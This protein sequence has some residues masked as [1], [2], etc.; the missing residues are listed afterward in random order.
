MEDILRQRV[1]FL[2]KA[3]KN[4]QL[5]NIEIELCKRDI[6]HFFR[7]HLYTDTNTNLYHDQPSVIPFIPYQFQEELVTEI[8]SSIVN[9]TL[10]ISERTDL[11]NVFIEKS[12][13]MWVSWI[14][15]AIL[16][17]WFIFH[18]H[19]YHVISQK[20]TDVD[21]IWDIRSLLEKARFILN[22]LPNWM[23]PPW[24]TK[25]TGTEYNKYMSLSRS[26]NTGGITGESANPNASRSGTYNAIFMD[27]M[28]FMANA[29]TIN[30]AAAAA[31]PCRIFN[32]TPNGEGNEFYRMRKLTMSRKW[33]DWETLAPQIKGLRYHWS[34]HPLYTQEWYEWKIKGM[35]KE[36][37]AQELEIDYNTAIIGRVYSDFP[38]TATPLIYDYTKPLYVWMDNSHWW[39]DPNAII[40]MQP[41]GVYFDIIDCL[42]VFRDHISCAEIL[43]CKPTFAMTTLESE[44]MERWK[45]YN[46]KKAVYISDPYDTKS[47]MWRSTILDDYKKLWINLMIPIERSKEEQILKTRTNIYRIRWN[48]L[49]D[50]FAS[51]IMN[52]RYPET[53]ETSNSTKEN[54]LPV[55]DWTS[56]YRT[57]LE[58]GIT[59]MLENPL[60]STKKVAEDTRPVRNY[61]TGEL[62]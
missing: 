24:Y 40:L 17:Y 62:R 32:S 34:E 61:I 43:T 6:L 51:A 36:K 11:T 19:K 15:M 3:D 52:A 55:H 45:L 46:Y 44:F 10:P 59:Y 13:Q 14:I 20:E 50:D 47:K 58:Y 33:P 37:I 4:L 2:I 8:W 38:T 29:M 18:G 28:A 54:K 49:C 56:H 60:V 5:Q 1:E 26:D 22:N 30:T 48:N 7:N 27:E 35:T 12:R 21:K 23:L 25:K 41:N 57:A 31:T 42:Q 16:V 53:K 9:G 39:D